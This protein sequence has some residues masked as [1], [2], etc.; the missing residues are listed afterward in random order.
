MD[1]LIFQ[2]YL[3]GIGGSERVVLEI[4][5]KYNSPIYCVDYVKSATYPEFSEFEI[6]KIKPNPLEGFARAVLSIDRDKRMQEVGTSSM[7]MLGMKIREDYDVVSAHLPP[8]EWIRNRNERVCWYCHGPNAAFK[9]Y[10][11]MFKE[12]NLQERLLLHAGC[13]YYRAVEL[14]LMKKMETICTCSNATKEKISRY[15]Y[16]DDARV[17][18]PSIDLSKFA[19]HDY[20]K[21]FLCVSRFVPEKRFEYV[22]DAFRKF[23]KSRKGYK[24]VIAG[25]LLDNRRNNIYLSQLREYAGGEDVVFEVNPPDSKIRRLH[26]DCRAFLFSSFDEDW[27][28]VILEAMASSKPCISVNRGGPHE[29][30]LDGKTGFLVNSAEEMAGKMEFLAEH[31]NEC[32]R[33]GRAGRKRVE[34]NYTWKIFLD[35]MEK[36]FRQTAKGKDGS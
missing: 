30:I 1:V 21:F 32:E 15:L 24:L 13:A 3:N 16:R 11:I 35:K 14:P 8:S 19:L 20:G 4:A 34:Q 36:A 29:S 23:S 18:Y 12:R 6:R 31:Q 17:A 5:K 27:G 9:L 26:S 7:R 25:Y 22:I 10:D 28:I 2:P 33:M